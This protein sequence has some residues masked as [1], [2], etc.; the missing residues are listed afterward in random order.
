M[1]CTVGSLKLMVLEDD[2]IHHVGERG[3]RTLSRAVDTAVLGIHELLLSDF[4]PA[5][6]RIAFT[7][8]ELRGA[9]QLPDWGAALGL[10]VDNYGGW[11]LI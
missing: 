11:L 10:Q 2:Q 4:L 9:S 5:L 1:K 8:S 7:L 3:L 6:E